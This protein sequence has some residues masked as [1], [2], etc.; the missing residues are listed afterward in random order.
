MSDNYLDGGFLGEIFR[1]VLG[2]EMT[3]SGS[4]LDG[5]EL[6]LGTDLQPY[7][8]VRIEQGSRAFSFVPREATLLLTDQK[9][10]LGKDFEP[11][12]GAFAR[13]T[14]LD[15]IRSLVSDYDFRSDVKKIL[16]TWSQRLDDGGKPK[17]NYAYMSVP[18]GL[19]N[20][21]RKVGM[22]VDVFSYALPPSEPEDVSLDRIRIQREAGVETSASGTVAGRGASG[23]TEAGRTTSDESLRNM[24]QT[25]V[26]GF[27][28]QSDSAE[29]T[30]GWT[31]LP[32]EK[33]T[34]G[35]YYQRA[36]ETTDGL[37]LTTGMV[38][39]SPRAHREA[40]GRARRQR[41]RAGREI[42]ARQKPAGPG[43]YHRTADQPR[44]R[45]GKFYPRTPSRFR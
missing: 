43:L 38:E 31:I 27:G 17:A 45:R 20:F 35:H 33:K 40:L 18:V 21:V 41:G 3:R 32:N 28:N 37:G 1:K 10:C 14:E 39:R 36:S 44:N 29:T 34:D 12:F 15:A 7:T 8:D 5:A 30:F 2:I 13:K 26:V 11:L 22:R 24:R 25:Y 9:E 19:I 16:D 4:Y 42:S 23:R 6:N